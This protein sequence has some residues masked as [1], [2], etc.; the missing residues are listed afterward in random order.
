MNPAPAATL[1]T[2]TQLAAIRVAF[3]RRT[4]AVS[5]TGVG[6]SVGGPHGGDVTGSN[7]GGPL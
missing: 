6:A 4:G 7:I 5:T 3:E 2:T 1:A